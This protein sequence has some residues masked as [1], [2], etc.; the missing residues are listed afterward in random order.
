MSTIFWL[1]WRELSHVFRFH[2]PWLARNG[3]DISGKSLS[4]SKFWNDPLSKTWPNVRICSHLDPCIL[5]PELTNMESK[6]GRHSFR[7]PIT[8]HL[9]SS[10]SA[11]SSCDLASAWQQTSWI[12]HSILTKQIS[13]G[14]IRNSFQL[15][16]R[17]PIVRSLTWDWIAC[18]MQASSVEI[19]AFLWKNSFGWSLSANCPSSSHVMRKTKQYY[20][21]ATYAIQLRLLDL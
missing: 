4:K 15:S 8:R 5:L 13:S 18:Q 21:T 1:F 10:D 16:V 6:Y 3:Q 17:D 19:F 9:K 2:L 20:L 14:V 12:A 7:K 11:D